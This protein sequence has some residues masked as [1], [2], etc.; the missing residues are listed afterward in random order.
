M[1]T[2]FH[3]SNGSVIVILVLALL[4]NTSA[5]THPVQASHSG[6]GIPAN[7]NITDAAYSALARRA[8]ANRQSFFVY[9]DADSGV[10][11]GFPS[12]LFGATDK[13]HTDTGCVDDPVSE[14]GCSTDVN[15]L[16][17]SRGTVLRLTVDPLASGQYAGVNIEG[18]EHWGVNLSGSGYDLTG[19]T[20]IVFSARSPTPGGVQAEFGVGGGKAPIVTIPYTSTYITVSIPL[21]TL[22][23]LPNLSST[24]ILFAI[25]MNNS[26]APNGGTMLLDNIRFEPVPVFQQSVLGF[27]LSTQTFG[28]IPRSTPASGREPFP[29]DQVNR[30]ITTI[31]ESALTLMALSQRGLPDDLNN[32]RLIADTFR[33]ALA[34]DNAG[35]PLPLGQ[36]GNT[37]LH[38]AYMSGDVAL[39]NDQISGPA[40]E[41]QSR[42]SGYSCGIAATGYCL[43][44]DGASGGNNAFAILALANAYQQFGDSRYY[45]SA[46]EI[47][48][49]IS[50]NLT[51]TT[52]TGYGGYYLGYPDHGITPKVLNT[53][54]SVENNADIYAAFTA[55]SAIAKQRGDTLGATQWTARANAAGD[56]VMQMF[57]PIAGRFNVGTVPTGTLPGPGICANGLQLGNDVINTCDF[58]DSD[59][60][61]TL[62]MASSPRYRNM[63]DWRQPISFALNTFGV[64]VTVGGQSYSGFNIVSTPITGPNG[65]AWEFTGQMVVAMKY[66]DLLYATSEFQDNITFYLNQIRQAQLS[67]PFGD[68][69]G[70]AASTMQDG[71]ILPPIEQCLSTP[72]QCIPE[73]V[74]LAATTWAIFAERDFN[75]L[76]SAGAYHA[77]LP[78]ILR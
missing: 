23:P 31:Y 32:A 39:F 50:S 35:D 18:P 47:A 36:S 2:K 70:L 61:T 65:I 59:T 6:V 78:H 67:A 60:F 34:H 63:I 7:A 49:W 42:L 17:R 38:N 11:H 72:F 41:G 43:V 9:Q 28:V 8:P 1:Y 27:P 45:T 54:K 51:D 57:D 52:G 44:L 24:H 15:R 74:G 13:I 48:N 14:N 20:Q 16:D 64:T 69:N 37:G 22:S 76:N 40:L 29:V 3:Y 62:G 46:L 5:V 56:F 55:L 77:F 12:G 68:S 73:R 30:N 21:S 33:Y 66:V 53:G 25:V 4:S 19:A 71:D 26:Y 58:L 75:I 10:N